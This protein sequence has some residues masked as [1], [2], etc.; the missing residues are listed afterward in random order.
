M[1]ASTISKFQSLARILVVNFMTL[2][3]VKHKTSVFHSNE[4]IRA[5]DHNVNEEKTKQNTVT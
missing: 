1:T 2:K 3:D 5:C 4:K